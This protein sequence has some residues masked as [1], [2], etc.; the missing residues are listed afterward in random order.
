M[1]RFIWQIAAYRARRAEELQ[2]M[3]AADA[4]LDAMKKEEQ[5]KR[6]EEEKKKRNAK[7]EEAPP[8]K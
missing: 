8:R 2:E 7:K 5:E 3:A 1:V 4:K 6:R